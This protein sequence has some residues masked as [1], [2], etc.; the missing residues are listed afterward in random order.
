MDSQPSSMMLGGTFAITLPCARENTHVSAN[1][2]GTKVCVFVCFCFFKSN[3][4]VRVCMRVH[5]R[6][7]C[8]SVKRKRQEKESVVVFVKNQKKKTYAQIELGELREEH[9]RARQLDDV[10]IAQRQLLQPRQL[11]DRGRHAHE[12]VRAQI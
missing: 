6:V 2:V 5:W 10:V 12:P 4:S 3:S 7:L 9:D 8:T 11:A 1:T